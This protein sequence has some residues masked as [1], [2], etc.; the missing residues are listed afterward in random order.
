MKILVATEKP[1]AAV[2][3]EGI[4]KE[5]LAGGHE[6]AFLEKYTDKQQLLDAVKDADALIVRSDKI[7]PESSMPLPNSRSLCGQAQGMI[8]S[9]LLM[10]RVKMWS[11]KTLPDKMRMPLLNWC[12]ASWYTPCAISSTASRALN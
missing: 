7:T 8:P 11:L 5:V 4:K 2:A 1:F 9:I 3:V 10:P 12:S 6:I